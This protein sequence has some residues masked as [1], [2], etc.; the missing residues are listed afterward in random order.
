MRYPALE[1]QPGIAAEQPKPARAAPGTPNATRQPLNA[2]HRTPTP[3]APLTT[4][5]PYQSCRDDQSRAGQNHR[6]HADRQADDP[7]SDVLAHEHGAQDHGDADDPAG[8]DHAHGATLDLQAAPL[9]PGHHA[10]G[11]LRPAGLARTRFGLGAARASLRGG[12]AWL[13]GLGRRRMLVRC[14]AIPRL[15]GGGHP[16][17]GTPTADPSLASRRPETVHRVSL[18]ARLPEGTRAPARGRD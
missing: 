5:P 12:V 1:Y 8:R 3:H 7:A 2:P 13:G 11:A 9:S 16:Q 4:R 18:P 6:G 14:R 15:R 17:N 10:L